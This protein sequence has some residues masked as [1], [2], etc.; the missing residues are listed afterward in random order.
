MQ[1]WYISSSRR[2]RSIRSWTTSLFFHP[3]V[4]TFASPRRRR[5]IGEKKKFFLGGNRE[6][7]FLFFEQ[8]AEGGRRESSVLEIAMRTVSKRRAHI[9][10]HAWKT[11]TTG[12]GGVCVCTIHN[13]ASTF[14]LVRSEVTSTMA[15]WLRYIAISSMLCI[16]FLPLFFF[17]FLSFTR[18]FYAANKT[19]KIVRFRLFVSL[20]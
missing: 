8:R 20:V 2:S 14:D 18:D 7:S 11:T 4:P 1:R 13:A 16:G 10:T 19:G 9:R 6:L 3:S 12:K 15:A 5:R 17:F